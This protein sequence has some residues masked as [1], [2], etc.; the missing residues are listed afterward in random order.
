MLIV[1][2][3]KQF[4]WKHAPVVLLLIVLTNIAVFIFYQS[5]DFGKVTSALT[6][7]VDEGLLEQEWRSLKT[8]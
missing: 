1:P 2:T 7:F 4:D 3:E 5:Q 6:P 8:I